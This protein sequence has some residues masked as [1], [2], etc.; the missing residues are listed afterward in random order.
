M[1]MLGTRL[2]IDLDFYIE[3]YQNL[4]IYKKNVEVLKT[5]LKNVYLLN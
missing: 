1:R 4:N 5:L 3:H 2:S